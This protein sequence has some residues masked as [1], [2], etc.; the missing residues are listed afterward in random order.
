MRPTQIVDKNG[1]TTQY[2]YDVYGAATSLINADTGT[3]SGIFDDAGNSTSSTDARGATGTFAYDANNRSASA[4]FSDGT[5]VTWSYDA[6]ASAVGKVTSIA[7]SSGTLSWAY[8]VQGRV[9]SKTQVTGNVSESLSY[10]RDAFGK[11]I[12]IT[13]P[14]GNVLGIQY[15][16][17]NVTSMTWNG[18][19]IVSDVQYFPF[20]APESWIFGNGQ[21]Y[22]RYT[23]ADGRIW[24][25]L[26]PGGSQTLSY[27]SAGRITSVTDNATGRNQVLTYDALGRLTS[28]SGFTSAAPSES[29]S[30]TYDYNGNRLTAAV[31]GA[32]YTYSY[33]PGTNM[34]TTVSGGFR[35]NSYDASGNLVAD[36]IATYTYNASGKVTQI[37]NA[38]GNYSYRVNALGETVGR[39][40]AAGEGVVWVHD[41]G[42]HL[43]GE[44]DAQSGA[45]IQE[46]VWLGSSMIVAFGSLPIS[47]GTPPCYQYGP[48]YIWVDHLGTP[49]AIT[50]GA[51]TKVWEWFSAP[52]GDS[53]P[54]E[55]PSAI[56]TL[57]FQPRFL[58]QYV[59]TKSQRNL[60]GVRIYDPSLGRFIQSDPMGIASGG[61]GYSYAFDNPINFG[62]PSGNFG[63]VGMAIGAVS[64]AASGY[65][66]GNVP[67]AV[68][69]GVTGAVTGIF[70]PPAAE[71]VGGVAGELAGAATFAVLNGAS[72]SLGTI[73]TN[74]Y[75]NLTGNADVP[76]TQGAGFAFAVGVF[77]TTGSGEAFV[78]AAGIDGTI[79]NAFA[80]G[81]GALGALG[82]SFDPSMNAALNQSNPCQ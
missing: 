72:S 81:S 64:G 18:N 78:A 43:I 67:G 37:S 25:Y 19:A 11:V 28:F 26:M 42:G 27:D 40:S 4:S 21:E 9:M 47:C 76:A 82:T 34:L 30:Y 48:G 53:L 51:G 57:A 6:T 62:D 32:A 17:A 80:V 36:G 54:N 3:S 50:N 5:N 35:T 22:T 29:R 10:S 58:G 12:A 38:S 56:G 52:F 49:R 46:F 75:N 1:N 59:D 63:L 15:T 16:G 24:K 66:T 45:A 13:Y 20:G 2:V 39:L 55:N 71:Y 33:A 7:D 65:M 73:I 8:D 74:A 79:G 69:G 61:G 41:I 68:I 23:D 70:F 14:S 77:S 60:S 31:N 44:Y